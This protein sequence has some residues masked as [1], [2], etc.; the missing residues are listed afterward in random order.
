MTAAIHTDRAHAYLSCSSSDRWLSCTV[1]PSR[2]SRHVDSGSS[3]AAEGTKAHELAERCLIA[4]KDAAEMEGDYPTE[5]RVYVQE[6][7]DYIRHEISGEHRIYE[8]KLDISA[9][10]PDCFGT[11]DNVTLGNGH[12][13]IVDLKYGKGLL[14]EAENN[15]QLMLYAL[16]AMQEWDAIYGPFLDFTLHIVQPRLNNFDQWT[17]SAENL[18]AWGES[19]KPIAA[20]AYIGEGEAKSGEHCRFCKARHTC[21][22]RADAMLADVG[23]KPKGDSLTDVEIA[24]LFP[25]LSAIVTW[26]NDLEAYALSRAEAGITLPGLK[27]VEGRSNRVISDELEAQKRL[28]LAG[29]EKSQYLTSKMQGVTALEKLVGKKNFSELFDG[30]IVKPPGKPTLVQIED[31]RPAISNQEAAL[32]DLLRN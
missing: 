2:E 6:Y 10:V 32:N 21:R 7:L 11:A 1:A 9:Y 15:T 14:V 19:I 31:K 8:Q 23:N 24:A 5:M 13:H 12:C 30:I 3:F 17:I 27:V 29:F 26:A 4:N 28:D 18:K 16:G 25:K 20:M 22:E